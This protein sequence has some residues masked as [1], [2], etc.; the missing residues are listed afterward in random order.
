[1]GRTVLDALYPRVCPLCERLLLPGEVYVCADCAGK[2]PWAKEPRCQRCGK[3]IRSQ[4]NLYCA[5]CARK[6]H[7]YI[8][9]C[10]AFVYEGRLRQSV[11]KLKFFNRRCYAPFYGAAM[12]IAGSSFIRKWGIRCVVPV[13]M[14]PKKRAERG[15]DQAA[16]IARELGRRTGLPVIG[17]ALVRVRYTRA[18]KR[19]GREMRQKNMRNAFA[20]RP[21]ADIPEPV[22][23]VDD[24]Y[25]T[26]MTMDE[27]SKAL[28]K[29]GVT[30]IFFMTLCIVRGEEA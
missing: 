10:A 19:L 5:D 29:A 23:L 3:P 4:E 8:Q 9:G 13:P 27:A 14:H 18:S 21:G 11:D 28:R 25:T 22:L 6:E 2:L 12:K 7:L 20:V 17:D 30:Q 1:M 15:Y 26:G 16:L 24:I